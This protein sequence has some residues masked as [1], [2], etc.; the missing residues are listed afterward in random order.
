MAKTQTT[1]LQRCETRYFGPVEYDEESVM[2]F[3]AGIPAFEQEKR[4]VAVRQAVSEPL[5][6]LQSVADPNVCFATLPAPAAC[7]GFRL[8]MA[9]EDLEALG[10]DRARQPVIGNDV[11][12][13]AILSL[14]ENAPPTVNLLA[15]IVVNVHTLRGCQAI[16]TD[17]R[18][19]HREVLP[20]REAACS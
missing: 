4:F 14:T 2:V 19:S 12:C 3:P 15:P 17:S 9:P 7:P 6:F 10:L 20:M 18:Y 11:L 16:Q 8:S 13:L 5:V 1:T